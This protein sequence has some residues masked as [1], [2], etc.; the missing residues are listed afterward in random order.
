MRTK[1]LGFIVT[2]KTQGRRNVFSVARNL[3]RGLHA[4]SHTKMDDAVLK[5]SVELFSITEVEKTSHEA[6]TLRDSL[7]GLTS[8][9]IFQSVV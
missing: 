2:I 4:S 1:G 7:G 3:I 5:S 6:S 8:F 9:R